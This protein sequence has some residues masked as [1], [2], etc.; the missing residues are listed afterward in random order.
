MM[1]TTITMKRFDRENN[2]FTNETY[3]MTL[4]RFIKNFCLSAKHFITFNKL[5]EYCEANNIEMEEGL[6]KPEF[7]DKMLKK[8]NTDEK[9]T[10]CDTLGIGVACIKFLELGM[11]V[12]E[13]KT[14]FKQLNKVGRV[15]YDENNFKNLYSLRDYFKYKESSLNFF[16][17]EKTEAEFMELSEYEGTPF[18]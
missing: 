13:Y 1:N 3:E 10:M 14:N 8:M 16:T 11:T 5:M 7:I 15:K 9:L 4:E 17:E 18:I 12:E 6:K 2:T